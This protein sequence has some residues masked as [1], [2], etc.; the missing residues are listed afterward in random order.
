MNSNVQLKMLYKQ[1]EEYSN[2][3]LELLKYKAIR[4]SSIILATIALFASIILILAFS[5]LFASIAFAFWIGAC[6]G[7]VY[8]GFILVALIYIGLS[9]LFYLL[10][11]RLIINPI[12][13]CLIR[14]FQ[15]Q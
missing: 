10:R 7:A 14:L 11:N 13:N 8:Y 3:S 12:C 9:F 1:I 6:M 2:I 15:K 5:V 4:K